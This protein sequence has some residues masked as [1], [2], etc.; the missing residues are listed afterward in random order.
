MEHHPHTFVLPCVCRLIR[1]DRAWTIPAR[2]RERLGTFA[3]EALARVTPARWA[4]TL[5]GPPALHRIHPTVVLDLHAPVQ[6]I[7][8]RS[9]GE[10]A[11]VWQG[12]PTSAAL[13]SHILEFESI[14]QQI[15]TVAANI[16]VRAFRVPV[17]D[18]DSIDIS[19]DRPVR[20]VFA[21]LWL[22]P[23][24][25]LAE[26][27]STT[28][29]SVAVEAFRSRAID[30]IAVF[31]TV[32]SRKTIK[33]AS[34]ITAS[35]IGAGGRAPRRPGRH[36]ARPRAGAAPRRGRGADRAAGDLGLDARPQRP[37]GGVPVGRGLEGAGAP[38]DQLAGHRQWSASTA[39]GSTGSIASS[40]TA[41]AA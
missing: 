23:E 9:G 39:A 13:V 33:V 22:V 32:G 35:T 5:R 11:R 1:V 7:A 34:D 40:C 18:R 4:A 24:Y 37:L 8:T 28:H 31:T 26:L 16:L 30:G 14:R 38:L 29:C 36:P 25:A 17:A 19:V 2:R 41:S 10:A 6:R 20:R 27:P 12:R 21:R 15:A 3:F